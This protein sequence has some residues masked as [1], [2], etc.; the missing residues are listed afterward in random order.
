MGVSGVGKTTVMEELRSRIA[1]VTADGDDFHSAANVEKMAG[2]VPLT[3]EDRVPW[4]HSIAAW[5]GRQERAGRDTIVAC[6]ALRREYRD[7]LRVE[8][9][10]V[11]FVL[12]V[13]DRE[14]L[15]ERL[16]ARRGHYMPPSLLD[17]QLTT[18]E[19]SRAG[20][21]GNHVVA[22]RPPGALAEEILA[23]VVRPLPSAG[24][25]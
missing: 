1:T 13:A 2:G 5:I 20:R 14:L 11:R 10:G 24:R 4:L 19:P 12:L 22:D 15:E 16:A 23:R 17:S 25:G 7:I 9:P 18:L 8:S 21:A 6:S 3:D